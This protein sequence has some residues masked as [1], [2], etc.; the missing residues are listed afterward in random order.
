MSVGIVIK[1]GGILIKDSSIAASD[2]PC[3]CC[4]GCVGTGLTGTR[5]PDAPD[6][7][8]VYDMWSYDCRFGIGWRKNIIS[9]V[10]CS[11]DDG[12]IPLGNFCNASSVSAPCT[13]LGNANCCTW[14]WSNQRMYKS[15]RPIVGT[16]AWNGN[17]SLSGCGSVALTTPYEIPD[18]YWIHQTFNG[19]WSK[20]IFNQK[21]ISVFEV[22]PMLNWIVYGCSTSTLN[23]CYQSL[24]GSVVGGAYVQTVTIPESQR[25]YLVP[26][27]C[28]FLKQAPAVDCT[29]S[30][31]LP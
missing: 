31:P 5:C 8:R 22:D 7:Y 17:S 18:E 29:G 12:S 16:T 6:A 13:E 23:S 14:Q 2:D 9:L 28:D 10:N 3:D 11:T 30:N 21:G 26:E 4:G 20:G 15:V 27:G 24:W 19:C 25:F 1:D